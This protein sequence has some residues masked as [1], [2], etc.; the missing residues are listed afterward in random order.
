V[1]GA[2]TT[3]TEMEKNSPSLL[4]KM[5]RA[6]MAP[7]GLNVTPRKL[8]AF[9]KLQLDLGVR[10]CSSVLGEEDEFTRIPL[11]KLQEEDE[12]RGRGTSGRG[13]CSSVVGP[14]TVT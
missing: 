11:A 3:S 8:E 12:L 1:I 4:L 9:A 13:C 2:I 5:T 6:E 14:L 7:Q 10:C